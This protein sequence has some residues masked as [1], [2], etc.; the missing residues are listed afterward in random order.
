MLTMRRGIIVVVSP[1]SIH[2]ITVFFALGD[3]SVVSSKI[4]SS[5]KMRL[6][7]GLVVGIVLSPLQ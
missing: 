2:I 1:A 3:G 7:E 6:A 4:C 5:K